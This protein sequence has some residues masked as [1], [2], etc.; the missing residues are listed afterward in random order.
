YRYFKGK[1][2]FGFGFGLS[3][4]TFKY[5]EL[6]VPDQIST[7]KNSIVNVKVT[8]AGKLDGEEVVQLYLS[9]SKS[10]FNAPIRALKGFKRIFLKAGES[11]NV[12]FN[13]TSQDL[14]LV[15]EQGNL[16]ELPGS[17]M[18]SVGGSQP[19]AQTQ[20]SKKTVEKVMRVI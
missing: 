16:K 15:D 9:H 5:S 7:G 8:N 3:Y 13:L 12:S 14:S 2:V 4:T 10:T 19:D 20:V 6:Q 1:P 17:I 18:V 11:K